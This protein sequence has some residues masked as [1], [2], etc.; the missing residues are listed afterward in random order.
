MC[1]LN[2]IFSVPH[3]KWMDFFFI[4]ITKIYTLYMIQ[5]SNKLAVIMVPFHVLC[6]IHP[7]DFRICFIFLIQ[8]IYK[9]GGGVLKVHAFYV[10]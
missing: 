1:V 7:R 2:F 8:E 6:R 4:V 3:V 5:Q 9:V 10:Q